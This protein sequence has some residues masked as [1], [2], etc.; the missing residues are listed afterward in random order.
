[1]KWFITGEPAS[2]K[3]TLVFLITERLK[4]LGIK[5]DGI[6]TKELKEG[7][8]RIGFQIIDIKT[9]NKGILASKKLKINGPR[10]GK[11]VINLEDI[12]YVAVEALNRALNEAEI[13]VCDEIGTMELFSEDFRKIVEKIL[14]SEKP[15]LAVLHRKHL[16]YYDIASSNK[17]LINLT[18]DNWGQVLN[19][20]GDEILKYFETQKQF[21]KK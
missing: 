16:N 9:K 14:K 11:Y 20:L 8:E 12:R 4:E 21:L 7:G 1:M 2:G 19:S 10:L 13:I 15:L 17:K 3:T 18:R 5:V 6:I